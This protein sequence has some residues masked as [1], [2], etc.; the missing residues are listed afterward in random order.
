MWL[1]TSMDDKRVSRSRNNRTDS[2]IAAVI[3]VGRL[4]GGT[5]TLDLDHRE[6]D[7]TLTFKTSAVRRML[8][9]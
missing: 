9:K 2:L 8:P 5:M 7:A 6:M 4:Q 1:T 3:I